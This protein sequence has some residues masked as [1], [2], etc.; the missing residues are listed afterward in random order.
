MKISPWEAPK[1]HNYG[2]FFFLKRKKNYVRQFGRVE[3]T[4]VGICFD[5]V[6]VGNVIHCHQA[7]ENCH[8]HLRL[9]FRYVLRKSINPSADLSRHRH[10]VLGI[11]QI[12]LQ[13]TINSSCNK[14][15]KEKKISKESYLFSSSLLHQIIIDAS[16]L[17]GINEIYDNYSIWNPRVL[18]TLETC[19]LASTL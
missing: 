11:G 16:L 9:H 18:E 15:P 5:T 6:H 14:A 2:F 3:N 4:L 19:T 13:G 17:D 7:S 10:C 1:I 12:V 8:D